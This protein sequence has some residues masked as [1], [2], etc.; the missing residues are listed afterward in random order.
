MNRGLQTIFESRIENLQGF[1]FE[2]FVKEL[3]LK[4]Y[5]ENG[6]SPTRPRKDR[7]CDGVL[8]QLKTVIACFGPKKYDYS[9]YTAKVDED[10]GAFQIHWQSI[11]PNWQMIVNHKLDPLQQVYIDK[12]HSGSI[13]L[14]LD[15]LI[16]MISTK[17][18]VTEKRHLAELLSIPREQFFSDYLD[19]LLG[20]LLNGTQTDPEQISKFNPDRLTGIREKIQLN[21]T[22]EDLELAEQEFELVMPLFQ[23]IESHI[24]NFNDDEKDRLKY[25][26]V[27]EFNKMA[28]DF[29]EKVD[30]LA[31]FYLQRFSNDRDDDYRYNIRAVLLYLFEQC[32]IGKKKNTNHDF[33]SS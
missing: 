33:T 32:L 11:Y 16:S 30:S 27:S 12:K 21:Y 22:S 1:D 2:D 25:R 3:F 7:G 20:N 14:G 18:N 31:D 28:G 26:V 24:S 29:K 17:L 9:K 8:L 23:T 6:F 4:K 5:T 10:Y 15:Q 13:L 19:E